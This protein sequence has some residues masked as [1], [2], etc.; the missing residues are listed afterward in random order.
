MRHAIQNFQQT[1]I[2]TSQLQHPELPPIHEINDYEAPIM[3]HTINA[4]S[5]VKLNGLQLEEFYT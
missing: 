3:Q 1:S 4:M 2:S 5:S